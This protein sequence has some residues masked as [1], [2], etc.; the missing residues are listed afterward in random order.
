MFFNLFFQM[1][2]LRCVDTGSSMYL[3]LHRFDKGFW[4]DESA[5]AAIL[6]HASP[7]DKTRDLLEI[8]KLARPR[9]FLGESLHDERVAAPV[10]FYR[11]LVYSCNAEYISNIG[12][13]LKVFRCFYDIG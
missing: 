1:N 4:R 10:S 2:V 7:Q 13:P 9:P 3:G 11:P 5:Q 8:V 12:W 6:Q